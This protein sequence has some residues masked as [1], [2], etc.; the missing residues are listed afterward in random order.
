MKQATAQLLLLLACSAS[1]FQRLAP[2][3]FTGRASSVASRDELTT[4]LSCPPARTN[5]LQRGNSMSMPPFLK[6][7]GLKKPDKPQFGGE[8]DSSEDRGVATV[9]KPKPYLETLST[10]AGDE[11]VIAEEE[12]LSE[13][14]KLLKKVKEAGTA[15]IISY[16]LWELGFWAISVPVCSFAFYEATGH[17]PNFSDKEDMAKLGAEAF[18]F[19]NFARFAVPLR[20]GLALST[21]P[22]IDENIVK[23]FIKKDDNKCEEPEA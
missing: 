12:E 7:L 2:S 20:I 9:E 6:K 8:E 15:G 1:A 17:W 21:T 4:E 13:S 19:V 18:A 5:N 23:K 10:D 3:S 16:A 14:Q 11:C 22:W